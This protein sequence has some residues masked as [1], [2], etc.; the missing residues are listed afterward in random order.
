MNRFYKSLKYALQGIRYNFDTQANFRIHT[1]GF[2]FM[3]ISAYFLSFTTYEYI[4][5]LILS[6]LIFF[7][8]LINTAIESLVDLSTMEYHDL[9]KIAKDCAAGAVLVLAICT[10]IVWILIAYPRLVYLKYI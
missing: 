9:A 5:C 10:L 7:A 6:T 3:N 8:E 4:V 1:L 2:V